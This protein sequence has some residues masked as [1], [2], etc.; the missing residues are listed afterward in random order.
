MFCQFKL[1]SWFQVLTHFTL[2]GATDSVSFVRV[3]GNIYLLYLACVYT[4][5]SSSLIVLRDIV[6]WTD[7]L[8]WLL[9]FVLSF[10]YAMI[11]TT[12][13]H[14]SPVI[15]ILS[16]TEIAFWGSYVWG[17]FLAVILAGGFNF[18]SI[19]IWTLGCSAAGPFTVVLIDW[20]WF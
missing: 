15:L 3:T 7:A 16:N 10:M 5:I 19:V 14:D 17:C 18:L 8:Q 2:V 11:K 1:E 12:C 13:N 9:A 6:P 20:S 4:F